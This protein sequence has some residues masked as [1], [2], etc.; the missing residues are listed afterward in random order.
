MKAESTEMIYPPLLVIRYAERD[1]S[2][3]R[4]ADARATTTESSARSMV[5][6]RAEYLKDTTTFVTVVTVFFVVAML[7]VGILWMIEVLKTLR[8]QLTETLDFIVCSIRNIKICQTLTHV[9]LSVYSSFL[10]R[11]SVRSH[12]HPTFCFGWH[13]SCVCIVSFSLRVRQPR[14][15][16]CLKPMGLRKMPWSLSFGSF[17]SL[18]YQMLHIAEEQ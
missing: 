7:L 8:S 3:I 1:P 11:Y 2:S 12:Y 4:A 17:S 5:E 13:F 16:Y 14:S 15:S 10:R 18:R 6:F 9:C